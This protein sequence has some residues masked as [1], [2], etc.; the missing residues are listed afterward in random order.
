MSWH[1]LARHELDGA[2]APACQWTLEHRATH[3]TRLFRVRVAVRVYY[4]HRAHGGRTVRFAVWVAYWVAL[5]P[6]GL[7]SR[8]WA[9]DLLRRA[10]H[11]GTVTAPSSPTGENRVGHL[12][13][14]SV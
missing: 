11:P 5:H 14:E 4:L 12:F 2:L 1:E 7:G 8:S 13:F 6:P 10:K 3:L 9:V